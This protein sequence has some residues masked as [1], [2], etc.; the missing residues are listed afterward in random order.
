M[1]KIVSI[2]GLVV[3]L[4]FL[5]VPIV[6]AQDT[7]GIT[8]H[9]VIVTPPDPRFFSCDDQHVTIQD[10]INHA[11]PGETVLVGAGT[12]AEQLVITKPLILEGAGSTLTSIKPTI[13]DEWFGDDQLLKIGRAH[14]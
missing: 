13:E 4:S 1:L 3:A 8:V 14:V 2:V 7:D 9:C 10:A 6:H 11:E 5:S 12:Y